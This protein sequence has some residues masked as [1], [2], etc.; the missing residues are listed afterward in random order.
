MRRPSPL[1][2]TPTARRAAEPP[3]GQTT[4]T[5]SAKEQR[6]VAS[7]PADD[8]RVADEHAEAF[9]PAR[10]GRLGRVIPFEQ[11]AQA[12]DVAS[13]EPAP[14][15]EVERP[16]GVRDVWAAAR[17]RRRA[18][19]RE[20]RR[21]T[22]RQR[23]RRYASLGALAAVVLVALGAVATAYSPLFAVSTITVVGTDRLE[24]AAVEKALSGERGTPLAMI[25]SSEVK[26]AL[27]AFPLV[28]SYSIEARPPQELVV[29]IVERTPVGVVSTKAGFSLVDAAGVVLATTKDAPKG[30]PVIDA[31]GGA[32]SRAFRAVG[33]VYR[34]LPADLRSQISAMSATTTEDVT[35]SIDGADVVWGSPDE[36]REKARVLTAAMTAKPPSEVEEY[37]VSSPT[38]VVIR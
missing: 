13:Q 23:R 8:P 30:Y 29:R 7:A 19:R 6:P 32:G 11:P 5:L 34:S 25:D 3:R 24:A 18:L 20:V 31:A 12:D 1:P 21:F 14:D 35:L 28:E 37:D 33:A 16:L 4:E 15:A 38:A 9:E 36:P 27:V 10:S 2:S 22:V 17:A 26:A